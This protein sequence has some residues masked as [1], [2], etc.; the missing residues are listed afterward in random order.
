MTT[1]EMKLKAAQG[2][3][4]PQMIISNKILSKQTTG[5][6]NP[7]NQQ[8][9]QQCQQK[10]EFD[11]TL[12]EVKKEALDI[13]FKRRG[14]ITGTQLTDTAVSQSDEGLPSGQESDRQDS[15]KL[16]A[17]KESNSN[18]RFYGDNVRDDYDN[19]EENSILN[20]IEYIWSGVTYSGSISSANLD[21]KD[22]H[23]M[24][25]SNKQP[26]NENEAPSQDDETLASLGAC[27]AFSNCLT[28]RNEDSSSKPKP[29]QRVVQFLSPLVTDVQ[30]T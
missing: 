9:T 5:A 1:S 13:K 23:Q 26:K 7:S 19:R 10:I 4:D 3:L 27:S 20:Q 16:R 2:K 11:E 28:P 22:R 18:Y 17:H 24:L 29:R 14:D 25:R 8:K 30:T 6:M 12:A 15:D 21:L